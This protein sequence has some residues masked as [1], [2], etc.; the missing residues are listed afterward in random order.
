MI[1]SDV[2]TYLGNSI[3]L[4][5]KVEE[6]DPTPVTKWKRKNEALFLT[7]NIKYE[8]DTDGTLVI[9]DLEYSDEGVYTCYAENSEGI[10]QDDVTVTVKGLMK[11]LNFLKKSI[12][13]NFEI[14]NIKMFIKINR[15]Q[16]FPNR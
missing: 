12:L 4:L 9:R 10:V 3:Q 5:C 6:G 14:H 7:T 16:I 8:V 2:V 11:K 15:F 1:S 13:L